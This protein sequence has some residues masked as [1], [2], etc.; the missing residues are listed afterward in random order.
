[1]MREKKGE[2][3]GAAVECNS[4][5]T[6]IYYY[7]FARPRSFKFQNIL[8]VCYRHRLSAVGNASDQGD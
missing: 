5:G 1:M 2:S 6:E 4:G 7:S 8:L 3:E